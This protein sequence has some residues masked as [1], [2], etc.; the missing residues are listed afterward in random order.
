MRRVLALA[1]LVLGV[2]LAPAAGA[3][4]GVNPGSQTKPVQGSC[5]D[6]FSGP[7]YYSSTSD[8]D[9]ALLDDHNGNYYVCVKTVAGGTNGEG[10]LFIDDTAGATVS[11]GPP[12]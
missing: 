1:G 12:H 10:P 6:G 3:G 11:V 2:A 4:I 5:P 7:I 9:I 8:P